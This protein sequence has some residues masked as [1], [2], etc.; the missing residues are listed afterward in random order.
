MN[1]YILVLDRGST[2]IK[3][4]VFDTEGNEVR[5]CN[6]PC[7]TPTSKEPGWWEQDIND[8]WEKTALAINTLFKTTSIL[9]DEIIGVIPAGQ[10]NGLIVIDQQGNLLRQGILSLDSRASEIFDGW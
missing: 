4:V 10:G 6:V 3:A 5:C 2:N 1:N 9:P 7:E 8:V